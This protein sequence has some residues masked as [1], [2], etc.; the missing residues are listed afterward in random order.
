MTGRVNYFNTA[1]F[2]PNPK[3]IGLQI[4]KQE[5]ERN[6]IFVVVVNSHSVIQ[7]YVT[8]RPNGLQHTRPPCTPNPGA[9]SNSCPLHWLCHPIILSCHPLLLLPWIF[10]SIRVFS[11]ES[12]LH[13]RWPK[14]CSFSFS[15]SPSNEYSGLISFRTDWFD[16][17]A[18]Q[19]TF[20]SLLQHHSSKASIHQCS[21]FF[22]VQLSCPYRTT[23]KTIRLTI[24]TFDSKVMSLHF[25]MLSNFVIAFLPR[26]K[27]LNCA[28]FPILNQSVVPSGSNGCFLTCIQ[29]SQEAGK[30]VWYYHH[31]KNSSQ[32]FVI[33]TIK[34]FSIDNEAD[35]FLEFSC[36]FYDPADVGNMIC[37]SSA[38]SKSSL[39]IWKFS[40]HVPLKPGLENFEHCFASM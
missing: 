32:F 21:V 10:P 11:N 4:E 25:N 34:G 3:S 6:I 33:H 19:G 18:V 39:N 27:G 23:G 2:K 14:Y 8:P 26:S 36:F 15:I 24:W 20:K 12:A 7:S 30:V 35:V 16:L 29:V 17:L 37:G 40:V 1:T 13:I 38:F 9:C 5:K 28:S 22:M 31:L